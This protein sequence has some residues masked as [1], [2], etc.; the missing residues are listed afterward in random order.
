[1]RYGRFTDFSAYIRAM[2]RLEFLSPLLA[3]FSTYFLLAA[4]RRFRL[5]E[6]SPFYFYFTEISPTRAFSFLAFPFS[7]SPHTYVRSG[8][9]Y[10]S[11]FICLHTTPRLYIRFRHIYDIEAYFDRLLD[12]SEAHRRA[13]L[14]YHYACEYFPIASTIFSFLRHAARCLQRFSI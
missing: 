5:Q 9:L 14:H 6:L 1:M 11:F 8:G 2:P 3:L 12:I 10:K 13:R 4:F 7:H